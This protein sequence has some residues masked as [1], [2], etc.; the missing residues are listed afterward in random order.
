MRNR[1]YICICARGQIS[2]SFFAGVSAAF[3]A[4]IFTTRAPRLRESDLPRKYF[5]PSPPAAA[6][7]CR[8]ARWKSRI[9]SPRKKSGRGLNRKRR[10][11][12]ETPQKF[13]ASPTPRER[14]QPPAKR[15]FRIRYNQRPG[16]KKGLRIFRRLPAFF[17][18]RNICKNPPF[19]K[20]N[21][22]LKPAC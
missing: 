19:S 14:T 18:C 11:S 15:G 22:F 13:P 3:F 7:H 16:R 21:S 17:Q 5:A 8:R 4:R 1:I 10:A 9:G 2:Q 12:R 20:L 6:P